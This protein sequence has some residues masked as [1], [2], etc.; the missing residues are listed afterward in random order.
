MKDCYD[1]AVIGGG[2]VGAMVFLDAV[3]RGFSCI[4]LEREKVGMQT[5]YASLG[6]LQAGL[7][8]LYKDR[9]LVLMNAVDCGLLK[10]IA[11]D[12]LQRQQFTVPV[13]PESKHPV[14]IWDGF[15]SGYDKIA[16]LSSHV[17]H[18]RITRSELRTQEPNLR[19]DVK[20]GVVFHEWLTD[21]VEFTRAIVRTGI[22][23]GGDCLENVE[24]ADAEI[25]GNQVISVRAG[26]SKI[27]ASLFINASGPWAPRTLEKIFKLNSF[28]TRMTKGVSIILKRK[29]VNSTVILF[30]K[31]DKYIAVL[32]LENHQTLIGPTNRDVEKNISEAPEQL[33]ASAEEIAD[34]KKVAR[35]NFG[36]WPFDHE[37]VTVKCGLR[38]QLNHQGVKPNDISHEFMVMDHEERDG[39]T[40]LLTVFGGKFSTQVRMAKETM[41]LA[42]I[43]IG[44]KKPWQIPYLRIGKGGYVQEQHV[45]SKTAELCEFYQKQYALS[46]K[47]DINKVAISKKVKSICALAPFMALGLARGIFWR[48]DR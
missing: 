27:S 16:R 48:G 2:A 3:S 23:M 47:D 21:P 17:R 40:N 6:L 41:D 20:G 32:P 7:N 14:W 42:E 29:L 34:L 8:Y 9:D 1:V 36:V 19:K 46:H 10:E 24:V 15:L 38:P 13:F 28:P 18:C 4:L 11:P 33:Q 37:I 25:S 39:V 35:A 44:K 43:K 5:T 22:V 26:E 30:D 31:D 12:F 45:S